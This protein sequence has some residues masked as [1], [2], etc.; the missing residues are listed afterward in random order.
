[1][2][3]ISYMAAYKLYRY[4]INPASFSGTLPALVG[5][6]D[7]NQT[8]CP[9]NIHNHLTTLRTLASSE[10][11]HFN[12]RPFV[13]SDYEVV[14]GMNSD[15]VY[16][17]LNNQLRPLTG[18]G[19]R[20]CYILAYH[21]RMRSVSEANIASRS[22]GS[23]AG[24]CTP[25]DNTWYY[26]EASLQQ[27]V[28]M[29]GGMY[30]VGQ[31]DVTVLGG[32]NRARPLSDAGIQY[33]HDHYVSPDIPGHILIKGAT[34]PSVYD[35][36]SSILRH[37]PNPDRRD[38]LISQIGE[39]RNVPDSLITTYQSDGKVNG[40]AATCTITT[41]QILNPDGMTVARVVS[42]TR[43]QVGNPTIRNCI[44]VRTDTGTPYKVSQSAWNG[45]S[46]G[47]AAFCPYDS[48]IRFVKEVS[49][50]TVW[51][52]FSDGRKQHADGFCVSDPFT[53][54]LPKYHVWVVPNGETLG[55]TDDGH[56]SATPSNCAAVT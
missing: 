10:Y 13:T 1:M 48:S 21:G 12:A 39:V 4:G 31:G 9:A 23:S 8:S 33:L 24:T 41:G 44:M 40:S 29:Y 28:L 32:T 43:R 47:A 17:V 54:P 55:H 50:P 37:V 45:F 56:W 34:Q 25:P 19:Q 14:K 5:H 22:K 42:G 35:A 53:T 15:A 51:R 18:P 49:D 3:S 2:N 7:V 36:N 27:Y 20:D 16:L 26:P 6:R 46:A 38:C 11:D 30:P 52:V